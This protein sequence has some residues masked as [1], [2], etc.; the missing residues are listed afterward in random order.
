MGGENRDCSEI[1]QCGGPF[2]VTIASMARAT[3]EWCSSTQK[4]ALAI[5]TDGSSDFDRKID[6]IATIFKDTELSNLRGSPWVLTRAFRG[7]K[8]AKV[9]QLVKQ[10]NE[11]YGQLPTKVNFFD[12]SEWKVANVCGAE[13]PP[14]VEVEVAAPA[15]QGYNDAE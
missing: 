5:A 8:G 4:C 13:F 2:R 11:T 3:V 14:G 15:P 6:S 7:G 1:M 10:F 9:A 12:D